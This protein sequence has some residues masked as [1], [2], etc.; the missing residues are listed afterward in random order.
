[1]GDLSRDFSRDEFACP[2]CGESKMDPEFVDRL[3]SLRDKYGKPFSPVKGGGYRCEEY[4]GKR[5][6]HTL[7]VAIDPAIP[8][9]DMYEFLLLAFNCGFTGIGAKQKG[10]RWQIH[11][12]TAEAAPGRPRPW[13]WTY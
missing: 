4:D 10:G 9:G 13:F 11:L 7:G 6:T 2:C 5:G 3:Q 8:R 1:M 12:D